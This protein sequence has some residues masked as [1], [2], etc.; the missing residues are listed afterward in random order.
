MVGSV[1]VLFSFL[2]FFCASLVATVTKVEVAVVQGIGSIILFQYP[3]AVVGVGGGVG[4]VFVDNGF[5]GA[6]RVEEGPARVVL[7]QRGM[8]GKEMG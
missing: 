6:G 3:A 7:W 8:V 2:F 5:I 1:H 4:R